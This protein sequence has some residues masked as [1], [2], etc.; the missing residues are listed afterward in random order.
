MKE[1]YCPKC[2]II[3]PV[4]SFVNIYGFENTR[5]KYCIVCYWDN[6]RAFVK[7]LMEGRDYCL[8]CGKKIKKVYDWTMDGKT[9]KI[10][11]H[12]DHMDPISLGGKDSKNNTVY[13]CVECNKRKRN[14]TFS[15]WLKF[16][17]PK[18]RKLSREI[19]IKKHR[20]KPEDFKANKN[21]FVITIN[22]Q[23]NTNK[24]NIK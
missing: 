18:Y 22:F 19:Y 24:I 1:K 21:E 11:I 23:L 6:E 12:C 3:K 8:Y 2:N 7:Q 15:E 20:R 17:A 13:C 5:G 16:L 4:S 10:S 14:K 9:S